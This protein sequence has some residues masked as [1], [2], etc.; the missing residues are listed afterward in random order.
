MGYS[1]IIVRLPDEMVEALESEVLEERRAGKEHAT[2][3]TIVA[4]AVTDW[5]VL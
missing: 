2:V 1:D 3:S 4:E 5:L